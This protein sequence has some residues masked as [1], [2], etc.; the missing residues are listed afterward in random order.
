MKIPF[1]QKRNNLCLHTAPLLTAFICKPLN[2]CWH[3]IYLHL[4]VNLDLRLF[5][6]WEKRH[7]LQMVVKNGDES[8]PTFCGT[9]SHHHSQL[10]LFSSW[11]PQLVT[12]R[13]RMG[14]PFGMVDFFLCD[15]KNATKSS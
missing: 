1:P 2:T 7:I 10:V 9:I 15:R 6:A 4:K 13:T 3:A 8:G 14:R 12:T 5:G 11:D